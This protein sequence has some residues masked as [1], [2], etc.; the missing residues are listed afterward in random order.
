MAGVYGCPAAQQHAV[1]RPAGWGG[2]GLAT[3]SVPYQTEAKDS[4]REHGGLWRQGSGVKGR[5]TISLP[6][7][8]PSPALPSMGLFTASRLL[9]SPQGFM[10]LVLASPDVQDT[11]VLSGPWRVLSAEG[12]LSRYSKQLQHPLL[13]KASHRDHGG[14]GGEPGEGTVSRRLS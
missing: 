4:C 6:P 13:G 11:V 12:A 8:G 2:P 3:V 1:G 9:R 14:R 5:S 7:M 10:R